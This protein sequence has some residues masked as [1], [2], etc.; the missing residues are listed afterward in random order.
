MSVPL[1]HSQRM[2]NKLRTEGRGSGV[3]GGHR[4]GL[5]GVIVAMAV[6]ADVCPRYSTLVS[7]VPEGSIQPNQTDPSHPNQTES[8]WIQMDA[9]ESN[10]IKPIGADVAQAPLTS[11]PDPC[12]FPV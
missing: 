12:P 11:T 4:H 8:K 3:G 9:T 5:S 2:K 1:S 6:G 7:C 10:L